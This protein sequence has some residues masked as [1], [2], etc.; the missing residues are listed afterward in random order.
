MKTV[1]NHG[2][3]GTELVAMC[4]SCSALESEEPIGRHRWRHFSTNKS[5]ASTSVTI[6]Q[7]RTTTTVLERVNYRVFFRVPSRVHRITLIV[8]RFISKCY[9]R[10]RCHSQVRSSTEVHSC[11]CVFW[12]LVKKNFLNYWLTLFRWEKLLSPYHISLDTNYKY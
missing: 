11:L 1:L 9:G 12:I 6:M 5:F 8:V 10:F 4:T 7:L 3:T 2:S